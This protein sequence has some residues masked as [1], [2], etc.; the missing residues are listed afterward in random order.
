MTD[1]SVIILDIDGG[2]LLRACLD[3]IAAQT[4]PPREVIVF[5][6]GSRTPA[7]E[8]ISFRHGLH[9]F[10]SDTNRGFAGGNNEAFRHATGAY[11]ALINNDVVLDRDWLATVTAALD[12]DTKLAAVQ[13]ILRRDEETIDGAGIDISGGTFRQVGRGMA[14]DG[15]P[16]NTAWGVSATAALYR[17]EALGDT[18]FD[19]NLFAYYEDVELCARL[20]DAGWRTEV[21]P[22]IKGTHHGSQSAPLLGHDAVRLRTRNR[23]IVARRHSG[24]GRIRALLWEDVKLLTQGRSSL[25]GIFQGLTRT[26]NDER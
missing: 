25:R 5:D 8:R 9:L 26:V 18:I 14:V 21:L 4:L 19:P 1:V 10:R 24:V 20:H 13:T 3:S 7:A 15:Q 12:A 6:N 11:I 16:G 17:R 2:D 22:V 23:Y